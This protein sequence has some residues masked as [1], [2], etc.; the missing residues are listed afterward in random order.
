MHGRRTPACLSLFFGM[1]PSCAGTAGCLGT[2]AHLRLPARLNLTNLKPQTLPPAPGRRRRRRWP[3][4]ARGV[5]PLLRHASHQPRPPAAASQAGAPGGG[6]VGERVGGVRGLGRTIKTPAEHSR[7]GLCGCRASVCGW[8]C[9]CMCVRG[10]LVTCSTRRGSCP[11]RVHLGPDGPG[12]AWPA[13][14]RFG[15]YMHTH[16]AL[17]RPPGPHPIPQPLQRT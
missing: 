3:A 8:V 16:L 2:M 11:G 6:W 4:G 9:G 5:R 12:Y 7:R 17:P 1:A 10:E 14:R 15:A 13:A